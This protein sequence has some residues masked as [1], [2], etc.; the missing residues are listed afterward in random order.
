M[1]R[2]AVT[3]SAKRHARRANNPSKRPANASARRGYSPCGLISLHPLALPAMTTGGIKSMLDK[4]K[5]R[6]IKMIVTD[7]DG[8]LLRE[9]KSI[10]DYTNKVLNECRMNGI[11]LAFATGRGTAFRVAPADLFDGRITNNGALARVGDVV[12]YNRLI[13]HSV[14][15]PLLMACEKQN[16]K[17]V[18]QVGGMHYSN[19]AITDIWPWL[20]D[21]EIVDFAK[22]EKDA[23]KL[24]TTDLSLE[25]TEFIYSQLPQDLY[26]VVT[27]DPTGDMLQIM[28]KEATKGHA[29]LAL[30]RFWN[31]MPSKIVTFGNDLNDIDLLTSVDFGVA[32]KN[33]HSEVLAAAKYTCASNEE[34]GLAH[35]LSENV[36]N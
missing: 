4:N 13:P 18:S 36:L 33:A 17:I 19:F 30:G 35:W 8:T 24:Y 6:S 22:H 31:I 25:K 29:A 15:R 10:S 12:I 21:F 34:D 11:K 27:Y 7:L 3:K 20:T 16:I 9:D 32:V 23:E 1:R 28:H 14:A 5:L 26:C 2:G